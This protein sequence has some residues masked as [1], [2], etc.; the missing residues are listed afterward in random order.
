M[1]LDW[2]SPRI[3]AQHP[4]GAS[5]GNCGIEETVESFLRLSKEKSLS[6]IVYC[7]CERS[8]AISC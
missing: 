8:E 6:F 7:H 5:P 3:Y 1:W 2:L 4:V